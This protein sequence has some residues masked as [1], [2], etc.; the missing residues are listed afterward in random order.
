MNWQYTPYLL[1]LLIVTLV[2]AGLAACAWQ[3]RTALGAAIFFLLMLAVAEWSLSYILEIASVDLPAK[4]VWAKFE[5]LG[6]ASAPV[7]WLAFAL[8]YTGRE[9]WLTRRS[10]AVLCVVPLITLLLAWTNEAHLLIWERLDVHSDELLPV[11]RMTYGAWF[12]VHL[13]FSYGYMLVGT[14]LII[15]MLVRSANLYRWQAGILLVGALAPLAS[16]ALYLARLNP[17]HP[18]DP[19]PFAFAISGLACAWGLFRFRLLDVAPVARD[20]VVEGLSD[21][22]IVLDTQN[23]V[24]DLNPA[25]QRIIDRQTSKVIGQPAAQVFGAWPDFVERYRDTVAA[26]TEMAIQNGKTRRIYDARI[27]PLSS[28]RGQSVGR[29]VV[30]RDI[31]ER[32]QAEE[33]MRLANTATESAANAIV[34]TDRQG[35]I[36]WVNPAFTHLTGYTSEEAIGQNPRLLRSDQHDQAFYKN[37]WD[38][39]LAGRVWRGEIT[40]RRKDGSLYT[41][42]QSITPVHDAQGSIAHFIAIKQDIT[43]RKQAEAKLRAQKQ[44]FENLVAVARATAEGPT[45]EATLQNVLDVSTTL[46]SAEHG[47]L[48]LL[49]SSG[50]VTH[51][52]LRREVTPEERRLLLDLVMSKGLASWVAHHRQPALITDI[53]QD[54]RWVRLPAEPYLV[55]SV[56]A[57]PISSGAILLGILTL[58]HSQPGHFDAGHVELM[59]AAADQMALAVRNAQIFDVQRRMADRQITL[60]EVLSAVSEQRSPDAVARA[61]VDAIV[62]FAGWSDVAIAR[63]DPDGQQWVISAAGGKLAQA[64]QYRFSINRG[65]IGRALR[66]ALTQNV[67]DVHSDPDYEVGHAAIHSE[68][69]VPIHRSGRVMGVLNLESSQL[70]AF[71]ADDVV[72]AESLADAIAL[73]MENARLFQT[74]QNER[75]Q[76]QALIK[77]TRDGVVLI[78]MNQRVL[79]INETALQLLRLTG[80]PEEWIGYSLVH[81]AR[82]LRRRS[83][84]V[85]RA[86]LDEIRRIQRGDEPPGEGEYD[87]P[88][89]T[90]HWFNLPVLS[91]DTPLGRL[92]V[93]RDVTDERAVERLREDMTRTMVH[94]LRNPLTSI[95]TSFSLLTNGAFGELAF[96]QREILEAAQRSSL[97][98]KGLVDSILDVS[99][100]ESQQM[101]L[102]HDEF[103]LADLVAETFQMQAALAGEK[104][105]RLESDAP[106]SLPHAWADAGLISRVLQN[107]VG[108]AIKFTPP[109]GVVRVTAQPAEKEGRIVL[110]VS[111]SDTGAGIPPEIQSRLFQK[112]VTGRQIG[113]GSG[114]GLAFCKLAIEAHGERIWVES[115]P[116]QGATFT[117][118]LPIQQNAASE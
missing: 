11:L 63:L 33:N 53:T 38:T 89:R 90:I 109:G 78:G 97:R 68:L 87:V 26:Q 30:L 13:V 115:T 75:S 29:L 98:M 65:I 60:Y 104:S 28:R 52:I 15:S 10:A 116:G 85:M 18:L 16:N 36:T 88:P 101:P 20:A 96:Q 113:R 2:L 112:F 62:G 108:N 66:T 83:P 102:K 100:L 80:Q 74:I 95:V 35:H 8:Q 58:T 59:Q 27:S 61:A 50:A 93:L 43:E 105:I 110:Q 99:R 86:V 73:A 70:A 77:S 6:I 42:E 31:T 71:N 92:L 111:V 17:M 12:G 32:K 91:G 118:N 49:D 114:L 76:L 24:I 47:S 107:L 9:K 45:L 46:T 81:L 14:G 34:I 44:L 67:P 64:T 106:F 1:P 54:D 40:N 72:L 103:A 5:Y 39:I 41:E 48:F 56:L 22:V 79:V 69:A 7:L 94:D 37:L 19:T 21:G 23:R 25:A 84:A 55:R 57:A 51:S 117:F 4:I 3:R 82:P